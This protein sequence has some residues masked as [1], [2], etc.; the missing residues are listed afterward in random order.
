[1]VLQIGSFQDNGGMKVF[2]KG[3]KNKGVSCASIDP[4][5][6]SY[7]IFLGFFARRGVCF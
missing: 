5:Q 3:T 7:L 4:T 1:M 2:V 6:D